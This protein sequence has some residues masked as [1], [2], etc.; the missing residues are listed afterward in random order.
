MIIASCFPQNDRPLAL[1]W[2]KFSAVR[3][4]PFPR[5][6]ALAFVTSNHRM[7]VRLALEKAR[8]AAHRRIALAL[9]VG[10]DER[11]DFAWSAGF[12]AELSP[13]FS[14]L[15]RRSRPS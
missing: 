8:A 6:P 15:A 9:P 2:P 10:S 13:C 1:D 3:I 4:D 14:V 5:Q 11:V 7:I 12:L